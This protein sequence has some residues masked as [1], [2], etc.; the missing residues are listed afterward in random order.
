MSWKIILDCISFFLYRRLVLHTFA[1]RLFMFWFILFFLKEFIWIL[2]SCHISS[3]TVGESLS[4]NVV[5]LDG[6]P[7]WNMSIKNTLFVIL[8]DKHG[9]VSENRESASFWPDGR[10]IYLFVC[11]FILVQRLESQS[12]VIRVI[13]CI[14]VLLQFLA[15]LNGYWV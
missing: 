8:V 4:L 13:I 10:L 14:I 5:N 7:Q 12:T 3:C 1:F 11:L 9:S 6:Y 2:K 15:I